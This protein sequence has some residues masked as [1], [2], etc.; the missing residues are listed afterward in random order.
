MARRKA[1]EADAGPE[2]DPSSEPK[3]QEKGSE[4]APRQ[5]QE[6]QD[7]EALKQQ[8]LGDADFVSQVLNT[9][10][11]RQQIQSDRDSWAHQQTLP[12]KQQVE[13]LS[14]QLE[15]LTQAND[16]TLAE[17][18]RLKE[19]GEYE[20]AFRL[21]EQHQ[22]TVQRES[23]ARMRGEQEASQKLLR[24]IA[25]RPEFADLT[26]EDWRTVYATAAAEAEGKGRN[27]LTA[28]EYVASAVRVLQEKGRQQMTAQD[29]EERQKEIQKEVNA[30][31]KAAGVEVRESEGGP[32]TP[33]TPSASGGLP[34][35]EE[36]ANMTQ[37]EWNALSDETRQ[38]LLERAAKM[39]A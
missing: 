6:P 14:A 17:I 31:L 26:R 2:Q 7:I 11:A 34:S 4:G 15:Q 23:A 36:V 25:A 33:S 10:T 28:D 30:A 20:E 18:N 16:P 21:L 24:G 1:S 3:G 39:S 27:Y 38:R 29:A 37:D 9:E 22:A 5:V 19:A 13:H 35:D 32:E 8:L 12:L